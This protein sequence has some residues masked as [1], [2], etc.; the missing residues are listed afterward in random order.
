MANIRIIPI[1]HGAEM[2]VLQVTR[3]EAGEVI[4][5]LARQLADNHMGSSTLGFAHIIEE[6]KPDRRGHFI[7]I[8][9]QEEAERNARRE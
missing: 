1:E 3:K 8:L 6:G 9:D 4:T 5:D 2:F 7:V